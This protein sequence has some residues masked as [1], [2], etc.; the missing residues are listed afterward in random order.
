MILA[1]WQKVLPSGGHLHRDSNEAVPPGTASYVKAGAGRQAGAA[2]DLFSRFNG[3]LVDTRQPSFGTTG[4]T[5]GDFGAP[6]S[7]GIAKVGATAVAGWHAA[8]IGRGYVNTVGDTQFRLRLHWATTT[9]ERRT[10]SGSGA[11]TPRWRTA[12]CW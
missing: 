1:R 9:T 10:T 8:E 4:L 3:M 11:V 2:I 6:G 7:A 12:R 5:L